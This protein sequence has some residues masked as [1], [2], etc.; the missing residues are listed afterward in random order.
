MSSDYAATQPLPQQRRFALGSGIVNR[1]SP[2]MRRRILGLGRGIGR[3]FLK[4]R[5][6]GTDNLP[7]QTEPLIVISNHF[8]WFDAFILT[9]FLPFQPV[10]LVATESQRKWYV[11]FFMNLFDGIPIWRGQVDRDAFRDA[12]KVLNEGRPLGVFPEGGINPELA[13]RIAAGELITSKSGP[14]A[15]IDGK[16]ARAKPGIALLATMSRKRILPVALHGTDQIGNN[17]RR[18]R[19]TPI[20]VQIGA[21]FG[22][23]AIEQ[24]LS[25]PRKREQINHLSDEMMYHVALMFPL[26]KRGPYAQWPVAT[27][28]GYPDTPTRHPLASNAHG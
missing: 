9:L 25:G 12:L 1:S 3:V 26:E 27:P 16:L 22:P 18:L 6:E 4:I 7:C 19:R 28:E 5:V 14:S 11:R 13:E 8:G 10:F 24:G 2:F 20:T 23:L 15:R 17:L 21:L